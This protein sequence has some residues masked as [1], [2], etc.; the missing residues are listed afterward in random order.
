VKG[1]AAVTGDWRTQGDGSVFLKFRKKGTTGKNVR[2]VFCLSRQNRGAN[3]CRGRGRVEMSELLG[4]IPISTIAHGL[5]RERGQGQPPKKSSQRR[6]QEEVNSTAPEKRKKREKKR[7]G[8]E[9]VVFQTFL[10]KSHQEK[11]AGKEL[12]Q[13][14]DLQKL[15]NPKRRQ[16]RECGQPALKLTRGRA[17][18]EP[19]GKNRGKIADMAEYCTCHLERKCGRGQEKEDRYLDWHLAESASGE[20]KPWGNISKCCREKTFLLSDSEIARRRH[21]RM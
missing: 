3:I 19:I 6:I 1:N 12:I 7:R 4:E 13:R 15:V 16:K 17:K 8:I 9:S 11:P 5:H 18:R 2:T 14:R 21:E 10:A 20:K